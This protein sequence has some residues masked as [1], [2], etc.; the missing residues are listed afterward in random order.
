KG[1]NVIAASDSGP[2][3]VGSSGDCAIARPTWD[4]AGHGP[5]ACCATL[6]VLLAAARLTPMP[7]GSVTVALAALASPSAPVMTVLSDGRCPALMVAA[8]CGLKG[9]FAHA[10]GVNGAAA[11]VTPV[12]SA[13]FA[14]TRV[15][16]GPQLVGSVMNGCFA[17]AGRPSSVRFIDWIDISCSMPSTRTVDGMPSMIESSP[18]SLLRS[19]TRD[20][21]NT[22]SA[23]GGRTITPSRAG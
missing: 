17:P 1:E 7:F 20:I 14:A 13:D 4:A 12:P 23:S 15:V 11:R 2:L 10:V 18:P 19:A 5:A 3:S 22:L 9:S 16:A 8:N 21:R 6:Q